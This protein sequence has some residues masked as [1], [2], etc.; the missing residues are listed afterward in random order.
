LSRIVLN[1][2]RKQKAI[3][4]GILEASRG[5]VLRILRSGTHIAVSF[6]SLKA[7]EAPQ[8]HPQRLGY[9]ARKHL[10]ELKTEEKKGEEKGNSLQRGAT[11]KW[12][13]A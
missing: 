13:C 4:F 7:S 8:I 11:R 10:E 5:L 12:P 3:P 2:H 6:I 9:A 1:V